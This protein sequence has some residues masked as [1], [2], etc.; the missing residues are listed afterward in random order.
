MRLISVT[1]GEGGKSAEELI[2][3]TARV[4]SPANQENMDTAPKLLAYL[5]AHKHWSPFEM[6]DM[7][8]EI[9]TSRAIAA[10]L[11]RHRSFSFQEFS[12]RYSEVTEFEVLVPRRQDLKN[13][14]NSLEDMEDEHVEWFIEAHFAMYDQARALY[15]EA[16]YRGVA[17]ECARFLLPLSVK[18]KLYMKGSARSWIH[19]LETRTSQ[20]TQLEHREI[21]VA[22]KEIFTQQFPN[23][24]KALE[25]T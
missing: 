23:T 11:L 2:V 18:T 7:T 1:G 25:W 16:L 19:Y 15:R 24:A 17:K 22:I 4:S 20:S 3:Y 6:A 12:Q 21:A 5:V 10:Q 9:E 8:I 13:R 14:Q